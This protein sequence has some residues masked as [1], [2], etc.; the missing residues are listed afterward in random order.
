MMQMSHGEAR[1]PFIELVARL[2]GAAATVALGGLS[3]AG[4]A[5]V[6]A[7]LLRERD[8]PLLIVAPTGDLAE[9]FA[10]DLRALAGNLAKTSHVGGA[11]PEGGPADPTKPGP[12]LLVPEDPVLP[13]GGLSPDHADLR[14]R[15][16]V[17]HALIESPREVRAVV[18]SA[19]TLLRRVLPPATMQ[20]HTLLAMLGA[21]LDRAATVTSLLNAGY[22]QVALCED[23]GTFAVRGAII[24]VFG[25]L[26]EL[27]FRI[28][29]L[30]DEVDRIR[31]Y[32]PT[33][34]RTVAQLESVSLPPVREVMFD[35]ASRDR[36]K[37]A[38]RA[39]ADELDIDARAVREVL[40]EVRQ[41][42]YF[43]GIEAFLP[44]FAES[45]APLHDYFSRLNARLFLLHPDA[46]LRNLNAGYLEALNE[47]VQV[48]QRG[49]F[50]FAAERY[51]VS[52]RE[53][54]AFFETMRAIDVAALRLS[55][56]QDGAHDTDR[57]TEAADAEG[58]GGE[59][60]EGDG[61]GGGTESDS[62]GGAGRV[63]AL[64]VGARVR[65]DRDGNLADEDEEE[66]GD[67]DHDFFGRRSGLATLPDETEW[68]GELPDARVN[69]AV[70]DFAQETVRG[71]HEQ[72][73]RRTEEDDLL[74]PLIERIEKA[75][76]RGYAFTI[77]CAGEGQL[78][79]VRGLLAGWK[80]AT[81]R[82]VEGESPLSVERSVIVSSG[83]GLF[84]GE[85]SDSVY[86]PSTRLAVLADRA[87][88]GARKLTRKKSRLK[89]AAPTL[90]ELDPGDYVV[91]VDHGIG[92]FQGLVK[93]VVNGA[94]NDFVHIT[95]RDNDR[96]YLPV[97]R[98]NLVR[99]Y[100]GG[101]SSKPR[102]DKL[103]GVTFAKTKARVKDAV[104][105]VA[106]EL[107]QI[108]AQREIREGFRFGERDPMYLEFEAAFPYEETPDQEKAIND[109]LRDMA[110]PR[111]MDRLVCGDVGY[112]KTEVAI[113]A[114]YRAVLDG[115][116][117]A[118]LVPT[119]V[120]ALQH[121]RTFRER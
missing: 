36:A 28:E 64:R 89:G 51:F 80:V 116:Q 94:E 68:L 31:A 4:S 70:I 24:D 15:L 121:D 114:A 50:A 100:T 37:A 49:D 72:L 53:V 42:R 109:V 7:R 105:A 6:A 96:L 57:E 2:D 45:L 35:E 14:E 63:G 16:R 73:M 8:E 61:E 18:V 101:E 110:S 10:S 111:P 81:K 92:L 67:E 3:G 102:L 113:R 65:L 27:P 83:V 76:R 32:D 38:I 93:L 118:V 78:E 20:R 112:G 74:K 62:V 56:L 5:L 90:R 33:T 47:R 46:V 55:V 30:G 66:E 99:K 85:L 19:R 106:A 25:P 88:F 79:R 29:L 52:P 91:H 13:F 22:Q 75:R 44:A 54:V 119:T 82:F 34:Q 120:L 103:G 9:R 108:Y 97:D 115:K 26:A 107:L 117:A 77:V 95:Y 84:L 60:G 69:A 1:D 40:E 43:M 87:I 41:G 71:L 48:V 23:P 11:A 12:V 104:L 98:L 21:E 17:C 86:D 59:S 39:L 58:E